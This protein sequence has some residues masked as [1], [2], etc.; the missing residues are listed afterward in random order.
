MVILSA[1]L[2]AAP[3][4]ARQEPAAEA[5]PAREDLRQLAVHDVAARARVVL[6]S[7][8][9]VERQL[10]RLGD[11]SSCRTDLDQAEARHGELR[12]LIRTL[13]DADY[14][15]PERLSRLRDQ[16]VLEDQRLGALRAR[17]DE[18]LQQLGSIRSAWL[19]RQRA[20]RDW[21]D[22]LRDDP[23]YDLVD[24]DMART[25]SRADSVAAAAAA[26]MTA[27]LDVQRG[28]ETLRADLEAASQTLDALRMSR[29]QSLFVRGEPVLLSPPHLAQL[30][31]EDASAWVPAAALSPKAYVNFAR[32]HAGLLFGHLLLL[33]GIA[34]AAGRIRRLAPP[35]EHWT[36]LLDRPWA[37]G[38]I[39]ST[40]LAM[41][42][43]TLAPPLWDVLVWTLFAGAAAVLARGLVPTRAL[44]LT[45]WLFA[46]F[47]PLFL[48]LEVAGLATPVFR[49]VIAGVAAVALPL[50]V[51]HARRR[52]AAAHAEGSSDP[53]RLWPLRLGALMWGV[54]LVAIILGFDLLG[55][56]VL[57]AAVTSGAVVLVVAL[58]LALSGGLIATLLRMDTQGRFLRSIAVP[59]ARR[60]VSLLRVVFT[61]AA[62]LI[63]AAIWELTP[64]PIATWSL[65]TSAGF[66]VVGVH[67]TIGRLL[68]A[69][70][71]LY[72]S[73]VVSWLF[74]TFL[75]SEAY[76]KWNFDRGVGDSINMLVHYTLIV[77]GVLFALGVLGVELQNFAIVVGAL[78]IGIGF[79]LQNVVNNF[80]SGLILL[81]ERP[82]RV[83]DTVIVGGEWG[84]I[85]K[86][87]LRSTVMLTFD[88]SEM[89]VPN[90]DLV[91]EKVVNWTLSNPIARVILRVGVAYGSDVTRVLQLLRE[92]GS[93]HEAVLAEPPPQALFVGFGESSLDFELRVWVREIQ[94]RL[95]VTS[96]ILTEI[97]RRFGEADIEIPFPQRD[98]HIRSIDTAAAQS[99]RHSP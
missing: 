41:Q 65:I 49:L 43:V 26:G 63:I 55:R 51:V 21:R 22:A 71:V 78:G 87:G 2:I 33:V 24:A 67:I 56:W 59:F 20:W 69:I 19:Q 15:R 23:D 91:S 30:R 17:V 93:I 31:Q 97:E 3:L 48:L 1:L 11:A 66:N 8:A 36:L 4:S 14:I 32:A 44:R 61:L 95:E 84:T 7:A 58:A 73:I 10:A 13:E 42:R 92:A 34:L 70:G 39:A 72:F 57:H 62:V 38:T 75:K 45:V 53:R 46:L 89:I 94:L 64:S 60:L 81:F 35:G 99:L 29:R 40:S 5:Q 6:D 27:L 85:R 96:M 90:A 68:F 82:V 9:Q 16:T 37:L 80:A 98:L 28:I 83:G 18:G 86:I 12:L 54:V 77:L 50:F 88:Q 25:I 47:Y 79:G 76:R 74:R 52:A